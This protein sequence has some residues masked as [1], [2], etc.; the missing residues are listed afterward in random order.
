[1]DVTGAGL[2]ATG[3]P[4][5]GAAVSLAAD[6]G[7]MLTGRLDTRTHP[8]L[9]DHTV[10]GTVLLPGTA[11]VELAIRAGDEVGC[12]HL[13][14]LTLQAP[15][16]V[17]PDSGVRVQV[18]VGA[19]DEGGFRELAVYSRPERAEHDQPWSRH[20]EG[21]LSPVPVASASAGLAAWP[22]PGAEQV[23]VSD[24]YAT[25]AAAGYGYGP[26]FQ[27]LCAVWR[28]GEEVF[29]EVILPEAERATADRFGLH[30]ALFDAA[31][32]AIGFGARDGDPAA[33]RLPF[34]WSGVTLLAGGAERL[35]V[36]IAPTAEDAL[37]IE[38]ADTT[39]APV[40]VV[41]ALVLRSVTA[42][43]L[44]AAGAPDADSLFVL[45]W[46]PVPVPAAGRAER[47]AVLGDTLPVPEGAVVRAD[48]ASVG[49]PV[50]E[51]ILWAP[52]V[53]AGI[54]SPV[55]PT[56]AGTGSPVTPTSAGP[57]DTPDST[58]TPLADRARQVTE[59]VLALVQDWLAQERLAE[60]RL[61]VVTRGA[62]STG[63]D[64]DLTDLA[65]A[66]AWGLVRAAQSENPGRLLLLDLD[67]A[68]EP[69]AERVASAVAAALE[70]DETQ[71]AV[72]EGTPLAPRLVRPGSGEALVPPAEAA[73]RLDTAA[74]GTLDGLTL[75]PFPEATAPLTAGQVRVSVR[76]A[77]VNFR[78]VLI[79]LGMV[80]GQ[81]VMGSEG[82]GVVTEVGPGVTRFAP[83]DH[84][85]GLM[86]GA[87]GPL[88]VTDERV[89]A[90]VPEGWSFEQAASVPVV[91]LT[92]YYGLVDLASVQEG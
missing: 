74:S 82:A 49:D 85:L 26:A 88:A 4:L 81:T 15:L 2:A 48:L 19:P 57:A 24:F 70:A 91:F 31:L 53:A 79:G 83:G 47:W 37:S 52:P 40:A 44:A 29:A 20:A 33:L 80:P 21:L 73:W 1:P 67:P 84:V 8:W 16:V 78:D 18:V 92:A 22:P 41:D 86:G 34:S 12:G 11:F 39:G 10:A 76:A 46:T 58:P 38:V 63:H 62:V 55:T 23:D 6:G 54:G 75:L 72:R 36:R 43:Q 17:P 61:V 9:A 77:G 69:D 42:D 35:R 66:P 45:D 64:A 5:L 50:P 89:L 32:H 60:S 28:R 59:T 13:T 14:E 56:S 7:V 65:A 30:P 90:P 68:E 87:L 25:A 71:I 51:V 3:H 27:G